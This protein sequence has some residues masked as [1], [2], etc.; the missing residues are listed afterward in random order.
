MNRL[1]PTEAK[2]L[3]NIMGQMGEIT[4][5][6]G[7]MIA[8]VQPGSPTAIKLSEI[9]I[10]AARFLKI[11]DELLGQTFPQILEA[12]DDIKQEVDALSDEGES[13][14]IQRWSSVKKDVLIAIE[15]IR[16][17]ARTQL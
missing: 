15:Q 16:R 8:I 7:P 3:A 1:S 6:I 10:T 17:Y 4:G 13:V 9:L 14:P 11:G 5:K 2:N 12:L